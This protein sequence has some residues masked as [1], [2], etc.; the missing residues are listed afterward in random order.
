ME[1]EFILVLEDLYE[2]LLKT[3]EEINLDFKPLDLLEYPDHPST[4]SNILE[5]NINWR[6]V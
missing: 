2:D 6:K 4:H 5:S 3:C 1:S